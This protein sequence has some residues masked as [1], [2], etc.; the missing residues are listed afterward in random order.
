MKI[1]VASDSFKGTL[2]SYEVGQVVK[3]ALIDD[4]VDVISISDGGLGM[5]EALGVK[6]Y[7]KDH[8]RLEKLSGKDLISVNSFDIGDLAK[9]LEDVHFEIACDVDNPLLGEHG[10]TYT[11]S[12]QKGATPEMCSVL[13][14]GMIHY[15]SIVR[16]VFGDQSSVPG[17]GAAGGLGYCFVTFFSG[18]LRSG[19]D[20]VLDAIHFDELIKDYE[21]IITG[22]GKIDIQTN[23][24]K[25]PIGVSSRTNEQSIRT[26]ALCGIYETSDIGFEKIF[27][28]VP[29]VADIAQSLKEP[30]Q[31][32]SNLTKK[33][34]KPWLMERLK[35]L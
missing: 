18:V 22:E 25:V 11:F 15:E 23:R 28:I 16:K 12:P 8:V 5:L 13:E 30:K 32:L 26:I 17:T 31:C 21:L 7:D 33:H 20:L 24:G 3:D 1:L 34:V 4:E 19:I 10:A 29:T 14:E 2:S 27:S 35:L 9:R 6:F